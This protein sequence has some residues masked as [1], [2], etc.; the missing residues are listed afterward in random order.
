MYGRN[1]H[2]GTLTEEPVKVDSKTVCGG[3]GGMGWRA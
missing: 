2:R 1:E 3:V